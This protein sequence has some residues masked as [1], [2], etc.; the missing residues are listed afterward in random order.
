MQNASQ[1][2]KEAHLSLKMTWTCLIKINWKSSG[3]VALKFEMGVMEIQNVLG[4][5]YAIIKLWRNK[6]FLSHTTTTNE[7]KYAGL[8]SFFSALFFLIYVAF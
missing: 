3:I 4:N 8:K 6:I 1:H 5:I 2:D 7:K